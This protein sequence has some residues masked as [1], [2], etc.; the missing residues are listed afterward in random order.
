MVLAAGYCIARLQA[1]RANSKADRSQVGK[2]KWRPALG[3]TAQKTLAVPQQDANGLSTDARHQ[4]PLDG[5][6]SHE[7]NAPPRLPFWRIAANH[8]DD[9]LLLVGV[10]YFAGTGALFLIQG[11]IQSSLLIA[12]A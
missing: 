9:A 4:F 12:M 3:S 11:A 6:L 2:V 8:R 1:N 5:F 10:Q 7:P